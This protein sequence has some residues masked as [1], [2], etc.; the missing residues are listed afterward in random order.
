MDHWWGP[1]VTLFVRTEAFST[2]LAEDIRRVMGEELP[3]EIR[4]F[5]THMHEAD[6]ATGSVFMTTT[7]T[8]PINHMV[9]TTTARRFFAH[10]LGAHPLDDPLSQPQWLAMPE[11]H[12]RTVAS[13]G[14]WYDEPGEVTRARDILRWYPDQI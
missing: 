9:V 14:V 5:P 12:L 3:F 7:A 10:Y 4:G 8:R 6:R 13:G 1:R 11:Q 2:E